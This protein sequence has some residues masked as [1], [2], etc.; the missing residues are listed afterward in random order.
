MTD[1]EEFEKFITDYDNYDFA[2]TWLA[3]QAQQKKIDELEAENPQ[4]ECI[5][6]GG[7]GVGYLHDECGTQVMCETCQGM[8]TISTVQ[9]QAIR[10]K[11]LEAQLAE[12]NKRIERMIE[13][14][15]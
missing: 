12:A 3:W 9:A 14:E 1:R 6:C 8:R 11:E 13:E 2:F 5:E 7:E 10:I 15:R 4:E